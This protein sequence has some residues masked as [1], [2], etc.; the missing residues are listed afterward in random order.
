[1]NA[2]NKFAPHAHWLLRIGL[3]SVF[4]YHGVGKFGNLAGMAESMQMPVFMIF[5]LGVIEVGGAVFILAGAVSKEWMTRVAGLGFAGMMV[6]AIVLVHAQH[7]WN[8]IGNMGM[9][10]QVT[11]LLTSLY[12]VIVGNTK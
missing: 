2:L 3:A 1:M 6:G 9:E 7:G 10:F 12:F 11:L 5:M 8:S 4:M